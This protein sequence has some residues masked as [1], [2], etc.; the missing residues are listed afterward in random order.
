[1]F[2][3]LSK[4][5]ITV[6]VIFVISLLVVIGT[7]ILGS[8]EQQTTQYNNNNNDTGVTSNNSIPVINGTEPEIVYDP[9]DYNISISSN[10]RFDN[11]TYTGL[12]NIKNIQ[13]PNEYFIVDIVLDDSEDLIYRSNKLY[14]NEVIETITIDKKIDTGTYPA[15]VTFNIY[16]KNTDNYLTSI[17]VGITV[18][19][20]N[21]IL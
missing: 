12:A 13:N 2:I 14:S 16:D 9:N 15:T 5:Q 7:I 8:Q 19:L 11:N 20:V 21:L 3:S 1:M 6:R 18:S 17:V 4:K 10:I